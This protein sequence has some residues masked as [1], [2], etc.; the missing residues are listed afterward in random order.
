LFPAR[1]GFARSD[2]NYGTRRK[3]RDAVSNTSNQVAIQTGEAARGHYDWIAFWFSCRGNN[4]LCRLADTDFQLRSH[5]VTR[6]FL[7]KSAQALCGLPL[8]GTIEIARFVASD[9]QPSV[10]HWDDVDNY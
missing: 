1:R 4:F 9:S 3:P 8:Q 6:M 5:I 10:I 7:G 2:K